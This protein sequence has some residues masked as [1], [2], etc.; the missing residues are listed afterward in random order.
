[1]WVTAHVCTQRD[2]RW[3]YLWG[4][5]SGADPWVP[6]GIPLPLDSA[7]PWGQSPGAGRAG[8]DKAIP[9]GTC[10]GSAAVSPQRPSC[11]P[12]ESH[13]CTTLAS[14]ALRKPHLGPLPIAGVLFRLRFGGRRDGAH[15]SMPPSSRA[16]RSQ[17]KAAVEEHQ[18]GQP[19][20]GDRCCYFGK[21]W[22]CCSLCAGLCRARSPPRAALGQRCPLPASEAILYHCLCWGSDSNPFIWQLLL[23]QKEAPGKIGERPTLRCAL[24]SPSPGPRASAHGQG[25]ASRGAGEQMGCRGGGDGSRVLC[26]G[27]GSGWGHHAGDG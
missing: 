17:M 25:A 13:S 15:F 8:R 22:P 19:M 5:G 21:A 3:V 16:L 1:M 6:T 24:L 27:G 14:A 20:Q 2:A 9:T 23:P 12:P 18:W 11:L 10:H 7:V 26:S 4:C